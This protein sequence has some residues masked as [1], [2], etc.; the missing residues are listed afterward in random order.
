MRDLLQRDSFHVFGSK[1]ASNMGQNAGQGKSKG[2]RKRSEKLDF[3][4]MLSDERMRLAAG[5]A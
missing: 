4:Q 5:Q 2:A 3:S 1:M